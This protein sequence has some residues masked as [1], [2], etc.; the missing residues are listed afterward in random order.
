MIFL[1]VLLAFLAAGAWAV[2]LW[3]A[4]FERLADRLFR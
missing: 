4:V 3:P 1:L 2:E